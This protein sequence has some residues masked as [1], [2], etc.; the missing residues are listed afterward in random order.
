MLAEFQLMI[1]QNIYKIIYKSHR[2][3]NSNHGINVDQHSK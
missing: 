1:N 2:G 3:I